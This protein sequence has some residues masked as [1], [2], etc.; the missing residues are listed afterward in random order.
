MF[1]F[2]VA[3]QSWGAFIWPLVARGLLGGSEG[4]SAFTSA[5]LRLRQGG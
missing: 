1:V 5:Q 4:L 2:L 3:G